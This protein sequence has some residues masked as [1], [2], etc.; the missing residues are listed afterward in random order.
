M[1]KN[2]AKIQFDFSELS[3]IGAALSVYSDYW[4]KKA[5]KEKNA[6]KREKILMQIKNADE[7]LKLILIV[8]ESL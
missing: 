6:I 1:S 5:D 4:E 2:Y 7:L 8:K 3:L